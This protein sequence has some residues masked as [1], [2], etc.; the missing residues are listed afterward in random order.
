MSERDLPGQN[1]F[2]YNTN[3]IGSLPLETCDTMNGSW[4]YDKDDD[5]W[6]SS[7]GTGR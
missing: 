7:D 5:N 2:G 1:T 3:E 4:G 6:K